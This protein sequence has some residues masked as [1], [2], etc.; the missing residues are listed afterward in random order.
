M[1]SDSD[2]RR[3]LMNA[4]I[5]VFDRD[6]IPIIITKERPTALL[7]AS[8][9]DVAVC[10]LLIDGTQNDTLSDHYLAV[11]VECGVEPVVPEG[12]DHVFI[13]HGVCGTRGR[14]W[15]GPE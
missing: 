6:H 2:V 8:V 10:H 3:E 7:L 1:Q 15:F 12:V 13:S 11:V 5:V 9:I 14:A 4:G